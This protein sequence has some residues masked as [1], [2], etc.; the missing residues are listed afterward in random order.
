[1]RACL[2]LSAALACCVGFSQERPTGGE[3]YQVDYVIKEEGAKIRKCSLVLEAGGS[4]SFRLGAKTPIGS[5][6]AAN[7]V[8]TQ[9]QYLDTG[10]N[11]NA[12]VRH[13][14]PGKILLGTEIEISAPQTGPD[15]NVG[16]NPTLSSV[17]VS[18]NSSLTPG[19]M[20]KIASLEDPSATRK[21][22]IEATITL[23]P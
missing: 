20:T 15:K 10:L 5:A 13:G 23:L 12:R 14:A 7:G 8:A 18:V 6:F 21:F 16:A 2:L 22:D 4:G 19:K 11:V 9:F 3:A 17:R 1:M